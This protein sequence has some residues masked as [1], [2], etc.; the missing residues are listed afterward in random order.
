MTIE[1]IAE[2]R[3]M[4]ASTIEGHAA[5]LIGD[6]ELEVNHFMPEDASKEIAK[7]IASSDGKG[8]G[9]VVAALNG[10]YSFGQVRM[11]LAV[12]QRGAKK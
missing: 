2:K 9:S 8:I 10:K 11:V 1:Q 12:V 7:A 4:S 6:G 5:K 3:G